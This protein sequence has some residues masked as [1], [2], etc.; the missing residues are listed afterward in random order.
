M[1][2]T[3][4]PNPTMLSLTP[5]QVRTLPAAD[6]AQYLKSLSPAQQ[7]LYAHEAMISDNRLFMRKSLE[8]TVYCPP[9][10]GSGI[11]AAYL[12]GQTLFFD[13]PS[14]PGYAKALL[15]T[16]NLSV[17]PAAGA[18][19]SYAVNKA[20]PFSMFS[21]LELDYNGPQ[22]TTHP[23][24]A[25]KLLDVTERNQVGAQGAV[26]AG[27]ND[28]TVAAQV[29][30]STP[31]NIGVANTWQGKMLLRLNPLGEDTVPGVLPASGVGNHPQLKLTCTPNF[32]GHDPLLNC[33][34]PTG[35]GSGWAV[36]VTG[37]INVDMLFLDGTNMDTIAPLSLNWQGEPTMQYTWESALTPFNGGNTNQPKTIQSKLKHWYAYAVIIDGNQS[38]D[39]AL[40]S[41]ITGF[42]LSPDTAG[43]QAFVKW[44]LANNISI[45]DFFLRN[46]RRVWGQ[47]LDEGVLPWVAGPSRGIIDA[48]NRNGSQYLNMQQGGFPAT[49]H[50]YQVGSVGGLVPKAGFAAI[51]PRVEM[52]L[53]SEN[54]AGL[55][56]G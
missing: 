21:K 48:D 5:A 18:G 10:G 15:I 20:A 38:T 35:A 44:N 12:A 26:L 11:T 19:A 23:Y 51:T 36:T 17:T 24:F 22:V 9:T 45:Y 56:V 41:N 33:I 2:A 25:C 16:Y 40:L 52:F 29:V 3:S 13:I 50:I 30:G 54:P 43:N 39:F 28:A 49:T 6:Q 1:A 4:T 7:A 31:I 55:K 14:I 34:S 27:N 46:V 42:M 53:C 37:T 32:L 8:K 47:D